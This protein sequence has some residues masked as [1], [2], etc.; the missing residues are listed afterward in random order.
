MFYYRKKEKLT[1]SHPAKVRHT[2]DKAKLISAN[3]MAGF[4]FRG[5]FTDTKKSIEAGEVRL[6]ASVWR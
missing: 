4:T 6:S 5:R 3:D 1:A 2:G